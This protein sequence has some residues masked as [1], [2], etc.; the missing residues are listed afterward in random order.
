MAV[1]GSVGVDCLFYGSSFNISAH[2]QIIQRKLRNINFGA[3]VA[4]QKTK[5]VF[6]QKTKMITEQKRKMNAKPDVLK[7][8]FDVVNYH[9]K[10]LNI[11]EDF[12]NIYSAVLFTQFLTTSVQLCVIAFQLTLVSFFFNF[13]AWMHPMH[14]EKE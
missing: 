5:M 14:P 8:F 9:Q 11:C 4:E 7:E 13:D 1:F 6:E 10:I 2:F 3:I 12:E